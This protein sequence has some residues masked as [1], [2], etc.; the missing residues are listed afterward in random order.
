MVEAPSLKGKEA[1]VSMDCSEN[2]RLAYDKEM[3]TIRGVKCPELC[4]EQC[5]ASVHNCSA[6]VN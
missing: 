3:D 4:L 5:A 6:A 1:M 2:D